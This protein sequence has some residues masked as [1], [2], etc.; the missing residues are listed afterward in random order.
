MKLESLVFTIVYLGRL[1]S[2]SRCPHSVLGHKLLH[3]HSGAVIKALERAMSR[4]IRAK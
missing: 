2:Y 4:T 1:K 3:W